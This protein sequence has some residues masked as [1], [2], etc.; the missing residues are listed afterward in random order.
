MDRLCIGL[1][2]LPGPSTHLPKA[3]CTL[4]S[5]VLDRTG[6][7]GGHGR[8]GG[9]SPDGSDDGLQG[10]DHVFDEV[11]PVVPVFGQGIA[12]PGIWEGDT[13]ISGGHST[14]RGSGPSFGHSLPGSAP[15][16]VFPLP[17][18]PQGPP[19]VRSLSLSEHPLLL[20]R[21]LSH[22]CLQFRT[23]VPSSQGGS[24][25]HTGGH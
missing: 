11:I 2:L 12:G 14:C 22:G 6:A 20:P 10:G 7:W 4:Q 8:G 23:C 3:K 15:G 5:P 24:K 25:G 13:C 1:R 18:T 21:S 9:A 16:S 17:G 19:A